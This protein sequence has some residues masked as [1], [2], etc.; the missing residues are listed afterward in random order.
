MSPPLGPGRRALNRLRQAFVGPEPDVWYHPG[1]RLPLA[2]MRARTGFDPRRADLAAW[3][4][5][6]RGAVAP[7]DLHRPWKCSWSAIRRVHDDAWVDALNEPE[8]LARVFSVDVSEV[9]VSEVLDSVRLAVGATVEATRFVLAEEGGIRAF[10][11]LGGFHHASRRLGA[12]YCAVNDVAVAI[13]EQ[14]AAGFEGRVLVLDLDAHP[15]DGLADCLQ[16]DPEVSIG[17]LSGVDW[18]PLPGA[19]DETVLPPGTGDA[20]YLA[21]LLALLGRCEP[22]DLVFVLAGSDPRAEDPMSELACTEPGLMERDTLVLKWIGQTPSVWLTAGGYGSRAWRAATHTGLVLAGRSQQILPEGLDPLRDQFARISKELREEDLEGGALLTEEDLEG[23]FGFRRPQR[24]RWLGFY[25][26]HGSEL[27]LERFGI[28]DQ[29]RRLGYRDFEVELGRATTGDRFRLW[30]HAEGQRFLLIEIVAEEAVVEDRPVL[31][32]HWLNLRHPLAAFRAGRPA[33]PGQDVP[34]L[35][36]LREAVMVL[37]RTA[38]RLEREGLA[39]RPSWLHVATA[40]RKHFHF[41]KGE[42]QGRFEALNRDLAHLPLAQ[43]SR[44]VAEGRVLLNGE[45]YTWEPG[46]QVAWSEPREHPEEWLAARDRALAESTFTLAE[47][48]TGA[49]PPLPSPPGEGSAR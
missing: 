18:G 29:L 49:P 1:F 23:L 45:P 39:V 41:V 14:R 10:N 40:G 5:L 16:D 17:S 15:P 13:A 47:E 19:V 8:T 42:R 43:R 44:A 20:G 37:H 11:L 35:G 30:G 38:E 25:S 31:F 36:M 2:S 24:S 7:K 32:V 28:L 33:L 26:A 12:G 27:A 4:L 22:A 48:S 46:L 34:G 3:T 6:E 21:A 9:G